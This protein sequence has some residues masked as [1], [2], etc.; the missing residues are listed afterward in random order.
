MGAFWRLV[1]IDPP[2]KENNQKVKIL[3]PMMS[4]SMF[5]P[6]PIVQ[7]FFTHLKKANPTASLISDDPSISGEVF[8]LVTVSVT[9]FYVKMPVAEALRSRTTVRQQCDNLTL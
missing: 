5:N 1:T 3:I 9:F 8:W 6:L 4:S 7:S 2:L